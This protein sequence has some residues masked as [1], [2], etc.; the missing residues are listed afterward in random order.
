MEIFAKFIRRDDVQL[1]ATLAVLIAILF[2]F[3]SM[4]S[5][6]L[7]TTIF[8]YLAIKGSDSLARWTHLPYGLAVLLVYALVIAALYFATVFVGPVLYTQFAGLPKAVVD[9]LKEYPFIER[10]VT[11]FID[12]MN[13]DDLLSANWKNWLSSGFEFAKSFGDSIVR[14]LLA[15]F[16]SLIFSLTRFK[17]NAFGHQFLDSA[18][19]K[20]FR[21]VY[22]LG[23][24]FVEKLGQIIETQIKIDLINTVLMVIG[25]N[26]IGMPSPMVL[27]VIVMI[28]GL[29]PVAGVL[30]S[31]VPLS[32]MAFSDG[33]F[34]L[35]VYMVILVVIVHLFES[36]FLHPRM[37]A[38][39]TEL[40]IFVTFLTL[41]VMEQILGPW[42]LI[43]GVPIV[44][45]FLDITG[46]ET[47]H[48][49]VIYVTE[50]KN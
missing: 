47:G 49:K 31:M 2:V 16:M 46:V 42:G 19:P 18:F 23:A 29:V 3:R 9:G 27:G 45:F 21:N 48:S 40:P 34:W 10:Y 15:I 20:F 7:L 36:Y 41:I 32:I 17:L 35:F 11:N 12:K 38:S 44:A 13:W 1:Y 5:V 8:A 25:F 24:K 22:F 30:I 4:I 39:R 37:M 14:V 6:V 33:G 43:V 26:L 50:E 28:L